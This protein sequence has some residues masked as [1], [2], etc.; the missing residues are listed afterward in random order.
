MLNRLLGVTVSLSPILCGDESIGTTLDGDVF[1][2][3]E[4]ESL[5]AS[6]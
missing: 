6:E 5:I 1:C 2:L 4:A 3:L